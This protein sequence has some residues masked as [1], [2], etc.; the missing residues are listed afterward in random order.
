[1]SG[2][3]TF[4]VLIGVLTMGQV[5]KDLSLAL[6]RMI[7]SSDYKVEVMY[8]GAK[9]VEASRSIICKQFLKSDCDYLLMIDE[10]NPPINNP[11]ELLGDDKDVVI[12]PTPIFYTSD[13]K[14]RVMWNVERL[15]DGD[16]T[17]YEEI[18]TGG[19]GCILIKRSVIEALEKP[20]DTIVDEDGITTEGTDIRFCRLAKEKGFKVWTNWKYPCSHYK[21]VNLIEL[22]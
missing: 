11:L 12:F 21:T 6:L 18:K 14:K 8:V 5:H 4:K 17:G 3:G 13:G 2:R 1:M 9:R 22:L 10:D 19:T 7:N 15:D 20:F 16:L